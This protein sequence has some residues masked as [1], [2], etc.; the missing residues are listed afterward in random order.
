MKKN[1]NIWQGPKITVYSMALLGILT[2]LRL[3]L[4]RIGSI[5]LTRDIRISLAFMVTVIIAYYFGPVWTAVFNGIMNLLIFF[6]FPTGDPF[7]IGYTLSAVI[8]GFI[9]GI[10]LYPQQLT[11]IRMIMAVT[12]VTLI[13][14]LFL[15]ALWATMLYQVPFWIAISTRLVKELIQLVPQIIISYL[16]LQ[17][18][19]KFKIESK[20]N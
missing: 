3:V 6:I 9:Y 14:N 18:V 1:R 19:S 11:L 13:V 5:R 10:F 2:A 7:F 12:L 4:S 17:V 20:L 16:V 8:G 15:N